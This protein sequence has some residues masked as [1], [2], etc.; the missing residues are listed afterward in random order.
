MFVREFAPAPRVY[1]TQRRRHGCVGYILY[2][3]T[4]HCSTSLSRA[5]SREQQFQLE[6]TDPENQ[7]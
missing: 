6:N 3:N 4:V 5:C 1:I 7:Q 2:Y